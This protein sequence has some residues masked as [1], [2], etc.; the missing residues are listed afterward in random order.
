MQ[1][2]F[3]KDLTGQHLLILKS[4]VPFGITVALVSPLDIG[5]PYFER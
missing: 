5:R 1:T 3:A 2:L 4:W